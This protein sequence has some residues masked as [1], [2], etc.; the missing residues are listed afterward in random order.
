MFACPIL[1]SKPLVDRGQDLGSFSCLSLAGDET[2]VM[3]GRNPSCLSSTLKT[4]ESPG[5][6]KRHTSAGGA[7][8]EGSVP[9]CQPLLSS[10]VDSPSHDRRL[11]SASRV[12]SPIILII[13][14]TVRIVPSLS[15]ISRSFSPVVSAI[16]SDPR[17]HT[18]HSPLSP[19]VLLPSATQ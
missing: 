6:D 18:R 1:V 13:I 4:P 16:V 15:S 7:R 2:R 10:S 9:E 11:V 3:S 19:A 5:K 12:P 17:V 8:T 14:I